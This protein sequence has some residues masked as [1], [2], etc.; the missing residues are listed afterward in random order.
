MKKR[1]YNCVHD[2]IRQKKRTGAYDVRGSKQWL[3][4]AG[5][6]CRSWDWCDHPGTGPVGVHVSP[7][8]VP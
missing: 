8:V 4:V 3:P 6:L 2:K 5:L 1:R 7:C